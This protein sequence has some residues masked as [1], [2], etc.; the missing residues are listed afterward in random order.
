MFGSQISLKY[1]ILPRE[2][3]FRTR[4]SVSPSP[5]TYRHCSFTDLNRSV[6]RGNTFA[7]DAKMK[8]NNIK[9]KFPGPGSY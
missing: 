1:S 9:I 4:T 3:R 8:A 2:E 7:Q 5:N 6:C